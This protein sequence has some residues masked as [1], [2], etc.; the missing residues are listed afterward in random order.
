M[1]LPEKKLDVK[2]IAFDLDDTLLNKETKIT[3]RTLKAIQ[4]AA[5]KGIY[6]VLCS[7]RAENGILPYVRALNVAGSQSGRYLVAFNGASVFDLH[8]RQQ[9]YTNSVD[10]DILTFVYKEAKSRGMASVVYDPS[11]IYSWTDTE[12]ARMDAK[13]CNLSFKL[14]DDFENFLETKKHPKMLV[15][16]EPEK[17]KELKEF[18]CEKL[19]GKADI[20]ISKPF[21]LEVM[22]HGVGK[23]PTILWLAEKLGI[24]KEQTMAFGDSMNDESMLRECEYGVAMS[25]GLDYIKE[26]CPFN[27][28]F[29]NNN[30]GIADFLENYVL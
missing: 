4:T 8:L 25:N 16:G 27:T 5:D 14:V 9:I 3:P 1:K 29:D 24:K 10:K 15:P 28:R 21:F 23:G 22:S 20:F 17:V 12:W 2:L 30:D 6:I 11:M 13:L 26:I 7:G 18:L 19:A